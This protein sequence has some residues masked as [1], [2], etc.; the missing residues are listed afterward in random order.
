MKLKPFH[1]LYIKKRIIEA[2]EL[3]GIP[4]FFKV[5]GKEKK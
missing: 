1:E 4:V 5:I 2:L 3:E